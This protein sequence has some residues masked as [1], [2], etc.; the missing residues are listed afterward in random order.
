MAL[1]FVVV[2]VV[3]WRPIDLAGRKST[4][5]GKSRDVICKDLND[6]AAAAPSAPTG[7]GGWSRLAVGRS[8]GGGE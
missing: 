8:A 6:K 7:Q 3:A 5:G 4:E 2:V 1:F